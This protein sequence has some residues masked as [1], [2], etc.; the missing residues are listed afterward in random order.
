MIALIRHGDAELLVGEAS[1]PSAASLLARPVHLGMHHAHVSG[2]GVIATEGL[3]LSAKMAPHLLLARVVNRIFVPSK[4]V[5]PREDRIAWFAR[6]RID[7][8]TL[9]GTSLGI[10]ERG[11][12]SDQVTAR[13]GLTMRLAL[14]PL[15]LGGCLEPKS[16]TMVGASVGASLGG[17]IAGPENAVVDWQLSLRSQGPRLQVTARRFQAWK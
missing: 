4:I 6:R 17:S 11:V 3:L 14:V 13:G 7:P 9:V 1:V 5:G 15:E 12:P 16:A 2:E 8:L 10:A